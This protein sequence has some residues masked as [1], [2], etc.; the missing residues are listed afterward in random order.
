MLTDYMGIISLYENEDNIK[1]LT[2]NRPLASIPIGGRYRVIDF[3][4]SNMVNSGIRSVG[5]LT[6]SNTRSLI[7]HLGNGKPWD[8]DRK[9]NGLFVFN[10]GCKPSVFSD[11]EILKN[12]IEYL[13]RSKENNVIISPSYMISNIDYNEVVDAH[14]KSGAD[15]TVVYKKITDGTKNFANCDVLNL[16][17]ENRVLSVGKNI[18]FEDNI[19]I[20]MEM[21]LIKK[22]ALITLIGESVQTGYYTTIKEYINKNVNKLNVAG[23][24]YKGYLQ[25]INSTHVYFK[26]NMDFLNPEIYKSMFSKDRPVYTKVL[27]EAPTKYYSSCKVSNALIAN[28][29]MIKGKVEN[30]IIS[31]RVIIGEGAEIKNCVIMQ[32]CVI[33]DNAKLTNIIIDKNVVI[34]E[35]KELKGDNDIPLIIEK[36]ALY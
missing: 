34:E 15:V 3:T 22:E 30:S 27:D 31:R 28:G 23:Y 5:I 6:Q 18:G 16:N 2:N 19:N 14:E 17:N 10:Y 13:Y 25:C 21:F 12:N 24:Q 7:D 36:K 9:I 20:S 11:I 1:S 4:L 35:G 29:C 32:N 33:K 8:L 26:A